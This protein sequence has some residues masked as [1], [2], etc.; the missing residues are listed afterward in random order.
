LAGLLEKRQS[1][2]KQLEDEQLLNEQLTSQVAQMETL[3]N[4]GMVSSMIAH[5]INNIL[6][7]LGSYAQLAIANPQD[8]ELSQKAIQKAAVNSARAA[9]ILQSM[10]N[11]TN[12]RGLEKK[13][14]VLCEMIENV[15]TCIARDFTKD[16]IKVKMSIADDL[17]VYADDILLEQVLMNLILNARESMLTNRIKGGVL[18]ISGDES[19]TAVT[20]EVC[21]SGSGIEAENLDK[22]FEPFYTTKNGGTESQ[23]SGAGLGL[24][25]C[26][27]IVQSHEGAISVESKP[28]SSTTF[29]IILPKH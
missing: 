13:R 12:T 9:N 23:R 17:V 19:A 20:I 14:H 24:A 15:F 18:S 25:F 8:A 22:I 27:K 16:G 7:P 21:D 11:L 2:Y 26:R 29:R 5:E 6:T 3:A 4:I 10:L 28:Y 1:L